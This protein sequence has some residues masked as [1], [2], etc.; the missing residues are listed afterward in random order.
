MSAPIAI[1]GPVLALE[2]YLVRHVP[3]DVEKLAVL[4]RLDDGVWRFAHG[5]LFLVADSRG[6]GEWVRVKDVRRALWVESTH[7]HTPWH[8]HH[9]EVAACAGGGGGVKWPTP[10]PGSV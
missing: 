8:A 3:S 2:T 6:S 10:R 5:Q 9:R 7:T 1:P 4:Q